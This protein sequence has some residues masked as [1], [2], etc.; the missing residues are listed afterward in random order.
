MGKKQTGESTYSGETAL[1]LAFKRAM[2]QA[3][4]RESAQHQTPV[5][6]KTALNSK[7]ERQRIQPQGQ[8]NAI[9]IVR[10]QSVDFTGGARSAGPEKNN[11]SITQDPSFE[12]ATGERI[13]TVNEPGNVRVLKFSCKGKGERT[14]LVM[15]KKLPRRKR[16]NK[17]KKQ[18][19]KQANSNQ[20]ENAGLSSPTLVSSAQQSV[21]KKKRT[22]I[23]KE[24]KQTI[25]RI[26]TPPSA[27][28]KQEPRVMTRRSISALLCW[29]AQTV[30]SQVFEEKVEDYSFIGARSGWSPYRDDPDGAVDLVIGL[31]FGTTFT[32]VVISESGSGRSWAVP[33]SMNL[34]NPYLI[35]S[36]VF[37]KDGVYK[38][39]SHGERIAR[40]KTPFL[41]GFPSLSHCHHAVAFLALIV[42]FAKHWFL[43]EK[44]GFLR[45]QTPFWFVNVGLPSKDFEQHSLVE[46][47]QALAWAGLYLS[48]DTENVIDIEHVTSAYKL[49]KV[50]LSKNHESLDTPDGISIHRDQVHVV[51]EIMA[52]LYGFLR[53]QH[54]DRKNPEFMLVDI[55]GGTIDS[56]V[57]NVVQER[58]TQE[59]KFCIFSARVEPLGTI[60]LH[61]QRV[62]W[63]L[64]QVQASGQ[65][66]SF[67]DDLKDIAASTSEFWMVPDRIEDYLEG[68]QFGEYT[69]DHEFL[70]ALK[71]VCLLE[72]LKYVLTEVNPGFKNSGR[73]YPVILAGG[74]SA[75][76]LYKGLLEPRTLFFQVGIEA[77]QLPKPDSLDVPGLTQQDYHRISVA[78]GLSFDNLG[79]V[80]TP[81]DIKELHI[82][83]GSSRKRTAATYVSKEMT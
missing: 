10:G 27:K 18:K 83:P 29:S 74:G 77:L 7:K 2:Q 6:E 61:Q 76:A 8:S 51:P 16:R 12:E 54:W 23:E 4:D 81:D 80:L 65:V 68:A 72:Q 22:N 3:Q 49:A 41:S 37:L 26:V 53:S 58:H 78:Y 1:A 59:L 79:K 43:N 39:N 25:P 50:A 19:Q 45:K 24:N 66:P 13:E 63:I 48:T 30:L 82:S 67:V 35:N 46:Q 71:K 57:F 44:R 5:D 60:N 31:D 56:T 36:D 11:E 75:N 55:G 69:F 52:Q 17:A 28:P 42:R 21:A 70:K 9:E 38:L 47:Y 20:T 73:N 15:N 40:L 34:K 62:N 33:L 64:K 32:K 14:V